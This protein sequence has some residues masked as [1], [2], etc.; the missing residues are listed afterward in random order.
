MKWV[1]IYFGGYTIV[2]IGIVAAMYK[3]G[4]VE[5]IGWGWVGIGLIIALGLGLIFTVKVAAPKRSS[6]EIDRH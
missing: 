3:A 2:I 1:T 4:I 6:V 5:R